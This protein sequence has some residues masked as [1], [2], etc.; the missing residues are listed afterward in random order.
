MK[1]IVPLYYEMKTATKQIITKQTIYDSLIL[2]YKGGNIGIISNDITKVWNSSDINLDVVKWLCLETNFTIDYAKTLYKPK[3]P[4]EISKEI[5][6]YTKSKLPYFFMYAKNKTRKQVEKRNK[7]TV[8][9]LKDIIPNNRVNFE[10]VGLE[11]FDYHML[12]YCHDED[13]ETNEAKL[14]IDKYNELDLK[15][16][17]MINQKNIEDDRIGNLLYTY[18]TIRED[19]YAI[20]DDLKYIVDVLV[21]YLYKIKKSNYKTTLW[22]SFGDV[23]IDNIKMNIKRKLAEGYIQC[24]SCHKLIKAKNNRHKYCSI[25]W[26]EIRREQQREWDKTKRRR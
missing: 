10:S 8:N 18:Q 19:I 20:N 6:K 13:I 16:Y 11:N 24:E 17:F 4:I 25:C 9:M 26:K 12:M 1:D 15:K 22:S 21:K 3:R 14:I 7:S 23:I 5:K 2:A